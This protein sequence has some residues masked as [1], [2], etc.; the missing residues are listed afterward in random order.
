M[1]DFVV[2][3]EPGLSKNDTSIKYSGK[4]G[5]QAF[6]GTPWNK[7]G[8]RSLIGYW[9]YAHGF[10][11]ASATGGRGGGIPFPE[12][13]LWANDG[14]AQG[15]VLKPDGTAYYSDVPGL[16]GAW[17]QK[18]IVSARVISIQ[19]QTVLAD[20]DIVFNKDGENPEQST[21]T[22]SS[23]VEDA[24]ESHWEHTV[25][26]GISVTTGVEVGPVKAEASLSYQDSWGVGGS[27]SH[28]SSVGSD[29]Q[30]NFQAEPGQIAM[31]M[32]LLKR[33]VIVAA[34]DYDFG[35]EENGGAVRCV[36]YWKHGSSHEGWPVEGHDG[37]GR[38]VLI[39]EGFV[40]AQDMCPRPVPNAMVI[41]TQNYAEQWFEKALLKT[42]SDAEIDNVID[43]TT[44]VHEVYNDA[45]TI[46]ERQQVE[47]AKQRPLRL[48]GNQ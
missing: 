44:G 5:I 31:M 48:D 33:G 43:N 40:R 36:W 42:G 46:F 21:L 32:G 4:P 1:S 28:S 7:G 11:N 47:A 24:V 25:T 37:N 6:D 10:P 3:I 20:K 35:V 26:E 39:S 23:A 9:C 34:V 13:G 38:A 8:T 12:G 19:I 18:K 30:T 14:G 22:L 15:W 45:Q 17:S 41:T 16:P 27:K 29:A 2:V